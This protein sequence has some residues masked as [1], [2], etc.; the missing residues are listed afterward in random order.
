LARGSVD[1]RF[2]Y[3]QTRNGDTPG[4]GGNNQAGLYVV[5]GT[6]GATLFD[7]LARSQEMA[8]GDANAIDLI[9]RVNAVAVSPDNKYV[10]FIQVG[11]T[12]PHAVGNDLVIVPLTATIG[13]VTGLPDLSN[14]IRITDAFP[15]DTAN[16]RDLNFDA[17]GNLYALT[18]GDGMMR[19]LSPGGT[20][21][22]IT[23]WD[24]TNYSFSVPEP[25]ALALFGFGG[26]A[27]LKRRLTVVS[28]PSPLPF[29][30][31]GVS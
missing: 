2:Y 4:A 17:A 21:Q 25:G 1:G 19:V 9:Q 3:M 22:W 31:N 20:S 10:A 6:T 7:S 28:F 27:L 14:I 30:C 12:A 24:G 13:T 5:D 29:T 18:S 8:G 26:L 15:D 11:T 23:A 16:G